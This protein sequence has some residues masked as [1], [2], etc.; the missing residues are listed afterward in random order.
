MYSKLETHSLLFDNVQLTQFRIENEIGKG[1][2][3]TVKLAYDKLTNKKLS[4]KIYPKYMIADPNKMR[5][6]KREVSILKRINHPYIIK[7]FQAIDE[8]TQVSRSHAPAIAPASVRLSSHP[9]ASKPPRRALQSLK[10]R[11]A[12][13]IQPAVC[14]HSP[15]KWSCVSLFSRASPLHRTLVTKRNRP[16]R[17]C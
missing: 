2:Y 1:A 3:A 5:N 13:P 7:L 6:V 14:L 9:P 11:I 8:R 17:S 15:G 12:D 4:L 16:C 10:Q